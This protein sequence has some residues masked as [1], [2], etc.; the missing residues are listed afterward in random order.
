MNADITNK[1]LLL[2]LED[3]RLDKV[4]KKGWSLDDKKLYDQEL[5]ERWDEYFEA[6]N[7]FE[8]A[9]KHEDSSQAEVK[10]K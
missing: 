9:Q 2:L 1:L 6:L 7:I 5:M 3:L 10:E 8:K 4:P